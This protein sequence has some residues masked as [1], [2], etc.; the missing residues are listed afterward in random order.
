MVCL[1]EH[2]SALLSLKARI[3]E[4]GTQI[5]PELVVSGDLDATLYRFLRARKYNVQLAFAMLESESAPHALVNSSCGS[6]SSACRSS[7]TDQSRVVAACT[8]Q[9]PAATLPALHC[10]STTPKQTS[11]GSGAWKLARCC[12]ALKCARVLCCAVQSRCR[13]VLRLAPTP[14]SS[15]RWT[16]TSPAWCGSA[17]PA[18]T[19]DITRR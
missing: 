11:L 10:N 1:Q 9:Q 15:S 6:A 18:A 16:C 12:A 14:S 4:A 19:S 13:G 2:T 3:A 8:G 17:G 7:S 5:P